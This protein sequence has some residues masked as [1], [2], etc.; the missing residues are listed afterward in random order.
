[1]NPV[2]GSIL[3]RGA[4]DNI[5]RLR[6]LKLTM[7]RT[8]VAPGDS[9]GN[10][11]SVLAALGGRSGQEIV[12]HGSPWFWK[13]V[14]RASAEA[15]SKGE[16]WGRWCEALVR[17][18]FD[19]YFDWLPLGFALEFA[20]IEGAEIVLPKLGLLLP[21][22]GRPSSIRKTGARTVAWTLDGQAISIDL[23]NAAPTHRLPSFEVPGSHGARLLIVA[24]PSLFENDYIGRLVTFVGDPQGFV[25][26]IG[27]SLALIEAA[28]PQRGP[29]LTR[30]IRWYVPIDS[31][32]RMTHNSFSVRDLF[33]VM[34]ISAAY[35]DA[36]LAEA[37]VHE[38]H[39]N[40]LYLL[41]E[42][43][44]LAELPAG[45]LFYSPFRKDP[46]PLDGLL[47]AVFVFSAVA[48]F[49]EQAELLPAMAPL[50]PSLVDRRCEVVRQVRLGLAQVPRETLTP[51]G[52]EIIDAVDAE[53]TRHEQAFG[54]L[55]A[56][57]PEPL[58]SHLASWTAANPAL[59]ERIKIPS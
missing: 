22:A 45:A 2:V 27:N 50:V 37:M 34:F 42:L 6:M 23:D 5:L 47:H 10:L 52:A 12:E 44:S 39:H 30:D 31:P 1:M 36:R 33:G 14:H 54:P 11:E 56:P 55:R 15:V 41:Q 21:A 17:Q 32:D 38:Y 49:I 20:A 7:L 9:L 53:I 4:T 3:A 24:D 43:E 19:S 51:T 29:Q 26:L 13:L 16:Q 57:L 8:Q 48:T 25:E 18:A 46:R 28:E 58:A 59:V 40:Q 35:Q